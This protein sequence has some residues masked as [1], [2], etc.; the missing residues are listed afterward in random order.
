[1]KDS[2]EDKVKAILE[3]RRSKGEALPSVRELR[4]LIGNKGS[5]TTISDAKKE[6]LFAT[7]PAEA[8]LPNAIT[9]REKDILCDAVWQLIADRLKQETAIHRFQVENSVRI[10]KETCEELQQEAK[11][12]IAAHESVVAE[13]DSYQKE[14][15]KAHQSVNDLTSELTAAKETI[16]DLQTRLTK[17]EDYAREQAAV[18]ARLEGELAANRK[19][20]EDNATA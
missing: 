8:K 2:T 5:M 18:R 11:Y 13:R 16:A 4:G 12:A 7:L 15:W 10:E 17:A 14:L 6:W 3:E 1:M 20:K 9:S 19:R